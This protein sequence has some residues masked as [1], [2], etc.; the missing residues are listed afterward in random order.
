M[1]RF[2]LIIDGSRVDPVYPIDGCA[3][4]A[5]A[6][7]S[8]LTSPA[9]GGWKTGEYKVLNN[10]TKDQ[11]DNYKS[12]LDK[13]DFAI[14]TFSGHGRILDHD[15]RHV[16]LLTIAGIDGPV[17]ISL[18][19]LVPKAPKAIIVCDA[20]REVQPAPQMKAARAFTLTENLALEPKR[21]A[22]R[23]AYEKAVRDADNGLYYLFACSKDEFA[24]DDPQKGGLFTQT[25]LDT[26]Q[27]WWLAQTG[28][29]T[30]YIGRAFTLAEPEVKRV[31][32]KKDRNQQ[33]QAIA[34]PRTRLAFPFAVQL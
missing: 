10:P 6:W 29:A 16:Q 22:Y 17:E 13:A 25:L 15:N 30:L 2:A 9:G 4:D 12:K 26:A 14:S 20:C 27:G 1:N 24:A 34:D 3:R 11:I 19:Y 28:A 32:Q 31:A 23:A 21:E 8:W 7:E 18:S 5:D 33:P